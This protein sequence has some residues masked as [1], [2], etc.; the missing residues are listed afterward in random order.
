[1]PN[2]NA[3]PPIFSA[4]GTN[5][6]KTATATFFQAGTYTLLVTITDSSNNTTT[7]TVTAVVTQN[8]TRMY[9]QP[10]NST[11]VPTGTIQYSISNV[12]DQFSNP[13]ASPAI[14]WSVTG[15]GSISSSGL[16]TASTDGTFSVTA[17]SGGYIATTSVTVAGGASGVPAAPPTAL[18]PVAVQPASPTSTAPDNPAPTA[19]QPKSHTGA[20][21]L[22]HK[23]KK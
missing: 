23:H 12:L 13:I 11:V 19:S 3:P 9:V 1:V 2:G 14:T 4:N 18:A 22:G 8:V 17:T 16:F 21:K 20:K 10:P 7:S 15:G 6:A 5:A